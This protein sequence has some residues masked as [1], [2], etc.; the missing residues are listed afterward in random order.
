VTEPVALESI[1]ACL[2]GMVP[3][4]L[5]TCSS[6][7]TPNVTYLSI[8][9][10]V[11]AERVALS[12]QFLNKTRAN[13]DENPVAQV[14]VVDPA[15]MARFA[16][17]LRYLHTETE[18]PLFEAMKAN[19]EAV[20]SQTGMGDVFRLRGVD[21]HRVL[22]CAP[23]G[24]QDDA[25]PRP[26][27][28]PD[29]LAPLDEFVRRLAACEA[30]GEATRAALE[31][32]EDLFGLKQAILLAG[33][34]RGDRLFA[35]ASNG[36][37]ASAA[38]AEVAFGVGLIGIAAER[39]RVV[40]VPNMARAR[41]MRAAVRDSVGRGGASLGP[42]IALPGLDRAQSAAA[43]PLLV[44]GALTGVLY[45]ES[46]EHGR[47]GPHDERLLRVLGGHLAAALAVLAADREESAAAPSPPAPA[48]PAA[49]GDALAVT[50]YQADD[51]VFVAGEYVIR[52]VPGRI[53]W[54]LLN[55]HAADGRTAFT[56]RELRLDERLGLPPGNDNL[57]A[58]LLVLRKRLAAAGCGIG[59]ERV[60]RGRLALQVTRPVEL[61]EVATSGPMKAAHE[62]R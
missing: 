23:A 7:G 12:R 44:Q 57:E 43:V 5:A 16:L 3:S 27:P 4:P 38:G 49:A 9:H 45:L 61:S 8:V 37:A 51:S 40:C 10:Y 35:V 17:D 62:P 26:E 19:L 15:T 50:Y 1:R 46:E 25:A 47:F 11:D 32:L 53:L 34:E 60:A 14:E 30:Y 18:G 13:L 24:D 28:Q 20:A 59:L 54:R 58:R 6:E 52:G 56:N 22:R 41:A 31:G 29:V 2:Q 42:E 39:R 33:D 36:Y 21:V 48:Q 55:E